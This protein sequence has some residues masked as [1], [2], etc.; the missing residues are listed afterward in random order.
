M[1]DAPASTTSFSHPR[2]SGLSRF[3]RAKGLRIK[4]RAVGETRKHPLSASLFPCSPTLNRTLARTLVFCFRQMS[5]ACERRASLSVFHYRCELSVKTFED[6]H[7]SCSYSYY[8][9]ILLL[10]LSLLLNQ[11]LLPRRLLLRLRRITNPRPVS[12]RLASACCCASSTASPAASNRFLNSSWITLCLAFRS[13]TFS[14][15]A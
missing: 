11:P 15:P 14:A 3:A 1:P 8:D 6:D 10:C 2:S 7:C 5:L 13:S 9:D 12:T 4:L